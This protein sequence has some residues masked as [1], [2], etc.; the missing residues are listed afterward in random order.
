[1]I[2]NDL[3]DLLSISNDQISLNTDLVNDGFTREVVEPLRGGSAGIIT[4]SGLADFPV[5]EAPDF[6]KFPSLNVEATFVL[7]D[8]ISNKEGEIAV[9][10]R[11]TLPLG[12]RFSDSFPNLPRGFL[13]ELNDP[14]RLTGSFL[15]LTS[16]S[17][18]HKDEYFEVELAKGLNFAGR[19]S[20]SG[21]FAVFEHLIGVPELILYGPVVFPA[22]DEPVAL[23]E[24]LFT[25]ETNDPVPGINLRAD[26]GIT[27]TLGKNLESLNPLLFQIYAPISTGWQAKNPG[28]RP[29]T[30]YVG[31]FNI[32]SAGLKA[33]LIAEE[34]I[35]NDIELV[36][37]GTLKGAS[38]K[39]LSTALLDL[40]GAEDSVSV[41]PEAIR[42]EILALGQIELKNVAVCIVPNQTE[43]QVT[44]I[45][46]TLGIAHEAPW[47]V[48]PDILK[49]DLDQVRILVTSPFDK[50]Q[51]TMTAF[52]A[53]KIDL[54]GIALSVQVVVPGFFIYA[55]Q[56]EAKTIRLQKL[57]EQAPLA[58]IPLPNVTVSHITLTAEPG[59][60]YNF[61]LTVSD[62]SWRV[63]NSHPSLHLNLSSTGWQLD[64]SLEDSKEGVP[65]SDMLSKLTDEVQ[66]FPQV[67]PPPALNYVT[68]YRFALSY[69]KQSK[70]FAFTCEGKFKLSESIPWLDIA[71]TVEV[72][73]QVEGP[74]KKHFSGRLAIPLSDNQEPLHFDLILDNDLGG[75]SFAA[76]YRDP[77]GR[78]ILIDD[79]TRFISTSAPLTGL[80]FI[81]HDALFAYELRSEQH[82]RYLFG[83]DI[84]GGLD[85]AELK[86][87]DL[88]LVNQ[89]L[90]YDQ[91][92]QL[93]FQLLVPSEQF[94]PTD[95]LTINR[96]LDETGLSLPTEGIQPPVLLAATLRMGK[97]SKPLNLPISFADDKNQEVAAKIEAG[98]PHN[99]LVA[100]PTADSDVQWIKIQKSFG[101]VYMERVGVGL[102]DG[103]KIEALLDAGLTVGGLTIALQGLSLSSPIDKFDPEFSL[104][105]LGIDYRNGP[106]EIGGAF[107]KQEL[108]TNEGINYT[109]F[110]GMAVIRTAKLTL[111]AVGSYTSVGGEPSMFIYAVLDY[112]LGGPSFFFIT[113]LAAG[114]GYNRSLKTPE[115]EQVKTFPL[116]EQ[117]LRPA[118]PP[119]LPA[120]LQ[121]QQQTLAGELA[122]LEKFIT[123]AVGQ[124]FLAIG[125]KFTSFKIIDSFALLV[126]QFGEQFEIDL[127]G[128]STLISPP[129][130]DTVPVAKA[131]LALKATFKPAEGILKVEGRLTSGSY[132]LAENCHL[133][134]GFA[135]YCWF[136]DQPG[137]RAGDFVLTLGGY[138]PQFKIPAHYPRVPRLGFHW[139]VSPQLTIKG[140]GYFALTAHAVMA[141][142]HLEALWHSDDFRAWI[143]AGVDFLI[144]WEPYHYDA[145]VY[146]DIGASYT[147]DVLGYRNDIT[148]ELGADLHLW[149]P[150][151]SGE[152]HIHY[153]VVSFSLKFGA[154]APQHLEPITWSKFKESFLPQL[155]ERKDGKKQD[156]PVCNVAVQSGLVREIKI[157]EGTKE[158]QQCWILNPKDLVLVTNTAVPVK[159]VA[160]GG[161]PPQSIEETGKEVESPAIR[162][163]GITADAWNST[164]KITITPDKPQDKL[165]DKVEICSHF[166]II[167]VLKDV[168]AAMWGEPEFEPDTDP[169]TNQQ[170]LRKPDPNA[171]KA[172]VRDTVAGFEI[173]AKSPTK[174]ETDPIPRSKLQF[175]LKEIQKAYAWESAAPTHVLGT[176]AWDE[177]ENNVA[178][179]N[180]RDKLLN[181]FGFPV[182]A[183]HFGRPFKE[184]LPSKI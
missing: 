45:H 31:G 39:N 25:F 65:L 91:S 126:V 105:G 14:G 72:K 112:P 59:A 57:G 114:F 177:A 128:V 127:L 145:Q 81:L 175:E 158:E 130:P 120:G 137:I 183:V 139:Q 11:F 19:W 165:H 160:F 163:V 22:S 106:V 35:A 121:A 92:L 84:E 5:S 42:D 37:R 53:G 88:P 148:F 29:V 1:M 129:I 77:F 18:Y 10:L 49:L 133:T 99:G 50:E 119:V 123:P 150:P 28:F 41:I 159:A 171:E 33:T 26:L 82:S 110:A 173:R 20:P 48:F 161:Q 102:T 176:A 104:D 66:L 36:F 151:F 83:V 107:L 76:V 180:E 52:L 162:P 98:K 184:D 78:P 140:D 131:Q 12:W 93:A 157:K 64:G 2:F 103:N 111:S 167:P 174:V 17:H 6:K 96:L 100:D 125:I 55:E 54:F 170:F 115:I 156:D 13:E 34:R 155:A 80:T 172:M 61:S 23:K 141:G 63:A 70:D 16:H 152:A 27:P 138:H 143:K 166:D 51:R 46:F 87:N 74:A 85:L 116:V 9:T 136:K 178:V 68:L 89:L 90:P 182:T 181:I 71:L 67:E 164:H 24:E 3:R 73:H 32:P 146:I 135:F 47:S 8:S 97:E 69:D 7:A 154:D 79:L 86:L 56:I 168:P 95:L 108:T 142:A 169:E 179:H 94:R 134:G 60:Y 44:H 144:S 15:Y 124:H 132:I 21:V 147:F 109:A 4:F 118:G 40:A 153:Y 101:P 43:F 38:L 75:S 122:N 117:V 149:G 30:A 58:G 62:Q 113:G